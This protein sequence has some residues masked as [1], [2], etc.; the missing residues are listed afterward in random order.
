[1]AALKENGYDYVLSIENED[2]FF[3]PEEG[4]LKGKEHLERFL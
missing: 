3:S 4:F 2:L 1:M